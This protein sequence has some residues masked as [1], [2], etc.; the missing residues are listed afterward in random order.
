[1]LKKLVFLGMG[2]TIAGTAALATDNVGY[3]AAQVGVGD[4]LQAIPGLTGALGDVALVSEQVAQVDSKNMGWQEWS[5]L[6]RRLAHHLAQVD[7]CGV[8]VTH[9]TD[10]L[11][12]TAFFLSQVLSP[13]L[14]ATKPVVLTCAMRPATSMAPDGPQ[15]VLD[16]VAVAR[17]DAARGVLV[18]CAGTIH[19]ARDVQK[20]HPYRLNAFDSGDAGPLGY[21]EEA[22]VRW[23]HACPV[24]K[25]F[26]A[27]LTVQQFIDGNWPRVEIISSY[28]AAS[29]AT[30][31]ALCAVP[32]GDDP[33]VRGLVVAGTGN[34]TLHRD[35]EDALRQVQAQGIVVV[36]ASRC[37]WGS[38]V[39]GPQPEQFPDSQGLSPLKAR[40]ALVLDLLGQGVQGAAPKP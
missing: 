37:A 17:S 27:D 22:Q 35:L 4:L 15:N 24:A 8:V 30:V 20:V 21:I 38:I 13:D 23:L 9:G 32:A 1:M 34:G 3:T 39:G 14:L 10:T 19:S 12:E 7:V 36:R 6:G 16:A 25:R 11:E 2:G 18:V 33:A 40:I 31:R 26:R 28:V 5:A 29:G